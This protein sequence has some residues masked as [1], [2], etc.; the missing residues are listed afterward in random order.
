M[1]PDTTIA[2]LRDQGYQIDKQYADDLAVKVLAF[3]TEKGQE[4][5]LGFDNFYSITRYNH[6]PLYAMVAYQLSEQI[7]S[8]YE[9]S[10]D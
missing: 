8:A 5:W 7:A 4:Y 2:Q 10:D 6:S 9:N 3:E 1:K